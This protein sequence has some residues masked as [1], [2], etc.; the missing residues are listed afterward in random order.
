MDDTNETRDTSTHIERTEVILDKKEAGENQTK[1]NAAVV[2]AD[3]E[4][5]HMDEFEK[6]MSPKARLEL[7]LIRRQEAEQQKDKQ[8]KQLKTFAES[9]YRD[10]SKD[11]IIFENYQE[12]F[13]NAPKR[14]SEVFSVRPKDIPA[15]IKTEQVRKDFSGVSENPNG[16]KMPPDAASEKGKTL[17]MNMETQTQESPETVARREAAMNKARAA[18]KRSVDAEPVRL[19]PKT[20]STQTGNDIR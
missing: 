17:S 9:Y 18:A 14:D 1:P 20:R 2:K 10:T 16:V 3:I 5:S 15:F 13:E 8:A 6:N 19:E 4:K 11:D 12:K 7:N